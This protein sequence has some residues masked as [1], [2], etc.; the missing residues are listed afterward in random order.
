MKDQADRLNSL[1][2]R[3]EII[4]STRSPEEIRDILEDLRYIETSEHP[5]RFLYIAPERLRSRVFMDCLKGQSSSRIEDESSFSWGLF[6]SPTIGYSSPEEPPK[7]QQELKISLIAIDEAHC[8]SQWGHDFRTS[9]LTIRDF[10][11][12]LHLEERGIPIMALTATA[13][14]KVRSDII[15]RLGL[16][17]YD[18]FIKG[19][20]RSNIAIVVREISKKEEKFRKITEILNKTPGV[21]IIY[22]STIKHVEEVYK[23]L[24]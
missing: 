24:V 10:V 16:R 18:L 2:I 12:T 7:V 15:E 17:K 9:Y 23:Y 21:G 6:D 1:G 3:A 22:C 14:K 4:N 11:K 5:I 20:N 19:F 13:T 8:I